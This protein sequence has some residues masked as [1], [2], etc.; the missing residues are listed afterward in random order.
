V[1]AF[2]PAFEFASAEF[3]I[4]SQIRTHPPPQKALARVRQGSGSASVLSVKPAKPV[5]I[6]QA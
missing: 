4:A 6:T 1:A 5:P 3:R 2:T